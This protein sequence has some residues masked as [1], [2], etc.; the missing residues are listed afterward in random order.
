MLKSLFLTYVTGWLMGKDE[1]LERERP[2][3]VLARGPSVS[4]FAV[5]GAGGGV[6]RAHGC[7]AGWEVAGC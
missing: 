7:R 6:S 1:A 4:W 2:V 5:H 3:R